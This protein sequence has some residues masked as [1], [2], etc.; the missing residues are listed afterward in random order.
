MN[1][2]TYKDEEQPIDPVCGMTVSVDTE[3]HCKYSGIHYYFCCEHCLL[4]FKE[5]PKQYIAEEPSLHLEMVRKSTTYTCPMHPDIVQDHPGNCPK[6]GM[7]LEP[8]TA[9]V[10]GENPELVDMSRRFWISV[11][12]AVPVFILAMVA[13]LTPEWLPSWLSMKLVQWIEFVLATPVVLWGGWPFFARGWQSIR[14]RNLNMFTLIA[15]GVSVAWSY[16]VVALLFPQ[17][18]PAVLEMEGGLVDVYFEAASMITALVLLGQVLELRARSRTNAAIQML[19]GLA[20]NKGRI[21]LDDGTEQ[22]IQLAQVQPGNTL[23]VRP[24]E[25]VPVD[26]TVI[27]GVSNVDESMVTGEPLPVEKASGDKLIGATVNGTGSLLMRAEKVGSDT[28]LAQIVNMVA[29]AQRTRAPIQKLADVVAGY[30]VPAVVSVA[31]IAF[32]I[33][34]LWGPEPRL[35]HGV[36][37]AVAVLIIA[38]PC[39]LGLATPISVMVGTGRGAVAG[40]LIKNAEALELMEQV[41]TLVIDKTGTLTEGKPRLVAVQ[42]QEGFTE[43]EVLRLA[44]CLERASEHPLAEAIIAGAEDKEIALVKPN[45][46]QSITGKGVTGT[47]DG[48][49]VAVGNMKLLESLGVQ[50][51]N[52]PKHADQQRADGKTVVLVAINGKAAGLVGVADP[53]KDS[54]PEAIHD[55][56]SEGIQIIIL[57]GDSRATALAV[58]SKLGIDQVQAEVLPEQ[59]TIAVKQLQAE[60]RVVAMAGDGINDAPALAQANVGIAMG[61]GTDVAMESAG[62]TLVKGDLRGIVRARRLSKATMRNI[63]QN[64]FF[65]FVYNTVGVPIAAGLLYPFFG[66]LLSPIIA[67]AAMSFSSV[68]VISNSLRLKRVKL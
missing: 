16:S 58:A 33:W 37:N 50:L 21:V 61:T 38:C 24:G 32:V 14:T 20:P 42:A 59:K 44:A 2:R 30:F 54:T 53:I 65:A 57:T 46:F 47:I 25:K 40:V 39:A 60:G 52:L 23:R 10:V 5:H 67:A 9:E 66:I 41:D 55:L 7:A 62:V 8:L 19:L 1:E 17:M 4:K 36:V 64:L 34:W 45:D 49:K 35:A 28:L 29:E 48:H 68:S 11:G 22:D 6:C 26:G 18:F 12:L 43:D 56:H 27:E 13:D 63:R 31:A 3:H 15:L 51:G